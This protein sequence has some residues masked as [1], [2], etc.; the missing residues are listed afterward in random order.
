MFHDIFNNAQRESFVPR[1]LAG[2]VGTL[3]INAG[4][5]FFFAIVMENH[6]R[7]VA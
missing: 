7:A 2:L 1:I 5:V 3:V 6:V 4:I